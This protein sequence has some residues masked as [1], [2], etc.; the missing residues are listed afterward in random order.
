MKILFIITNLQN[1]GAERVCVNLANYFCKFYEVSILKF[2]EENSVYPVE[3]D[4]N[5]IN[6]NLKKRGFNPF[7]II[8]K[9]IAQKNF[10]SQNDICISF[11]NSTNILAIISN[12]FAKKP[13]IITEH[14]SYENCGFFLKIARRIFYPKADFLTLLTKKD[15][16]LFNFVKNKAVIYNPVFGDFSQKNDKKNLIIF[17]GR[18][19]PLKGCDI[20]LKALKNVDKD[21]LYNWEIKILGDGEIKKEL[22]NLALKF[23]LNV[24]FLGNVKEI[25][26]FYKK[27]KIIVSTSLIEGLPNVL[28]ESIFF[29]VARIST[30]TRGAN[31]LIK[32]GFDGLLCEI[33]SYEE[34]AKSIEILIKKEKFRQI[35]V[36]N[37]KLRQKEFEIEEIKKSWEKIFMKVCDE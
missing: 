5:L 6:L 7:R 2:D 13:L 15:L 9:I 4:V 37:A 17:V 31:E 35:L 21:L 11:M 25:S 14:T 8:K 12:F 34:I 27:A 32:D 30:K 24:E 18:L 16:E 19:I 1:G 36:E 33:G 29:E 3:K 26:Q 10:M 23:N 28:I 20:F 22:E